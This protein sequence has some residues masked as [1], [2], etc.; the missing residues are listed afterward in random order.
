MQFAFELGNRSQRVSMRQ[1]TN[2]ALPVE[3]GIFSYADAMLVSEFLSTAPI[4][5]TKVS[6][7]HTSWPSSS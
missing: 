6:C 7:T 4:V 5:C 1:L 2:M 3:P